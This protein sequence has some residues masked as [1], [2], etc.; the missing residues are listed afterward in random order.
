M[1]EKLTYRPVMWRDR[2]GQVFGCKRRDGFDQ[3][4]LVDP[5]ALVERDQGE[6]V[7]RHG[8]LLLASHDVLLRNNQEH[9]SMKKAKKL[10]PSCSFLPAGEHDK[11]ARAV[12]VV[13]QEP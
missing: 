3:A 8:C 10:L 13:E 6:C 2:Q 7:F 12:Y 11:C 9:D 1:V 4:L 5:P